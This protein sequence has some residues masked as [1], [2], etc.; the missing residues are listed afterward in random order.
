MKPGIYDMESHEYHADPCPE[1]SLSSTGIKRLLEYPFEGCPALFK[2]LLDN[3]EPPKDV[4][5]IGKAA[6]T[7]LLGKGEKVVVVEADAWRT[8]EAKSQRDSAREKGHTPLL[9]KN[10]EQV[11]AMIAQAHKEPTVKALFKGGEAEKVLIWWDDE[12]KLWC[13]GMLDYSHPAQIVSDYKTCASAHPESIQRALFSYGYYVQA[14]FYLEGVKALGIMENPGF[15]F[16]FQEKKEPYLTLP[17]QVDKEGLDWGAVVVRKAKMLLRECLDNDTW[18]S[19][20]K[21]KLF[22]ACLPKYALYGLEEAHEAGRFT[23]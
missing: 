23:E 21:G 8:K 2:Y 10:Y 16:L 7:L 6:H 19:Y 20:N 13:R 18:P 1:V 14:A 5:D 3:P 9:R 4:W 17:V 11:Q 12:F 15:V 22:T